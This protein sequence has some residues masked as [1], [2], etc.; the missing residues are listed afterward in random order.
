VV[1][2]SLAALGAALSEY[3][4]AADVEAVR[5]AASTSW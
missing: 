1:E 2:S 5:K 3:G 4:L